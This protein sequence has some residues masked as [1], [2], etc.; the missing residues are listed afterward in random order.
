MLPWKRL[1][2]HFL[3]WSFSIA[4]I[5]NIFFKIFFFFMIYKTDVK[6]F[7]FFFI[8]SE[9]PSITDIF[10]CYLEKKLHIKWVHLATC[11]GI[12]KLYTYLSIILLDFYCVVFRSYCIT[13]FS[14]HWMFTLFFHSMFNCLI[15]GS[16]VLLRLFTTVCSHCLP[17]CVHIV[18][19]WICS[20]LAVCWNAVPKYAF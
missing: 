14:Y 15:P 1:F 11:L 20:C 7:H 2:N 16:Y 6:C 10:Y 13:A 5:P 19:H 3:Y 8:S 18:Y 17:L 4:Y 12:S 9:M